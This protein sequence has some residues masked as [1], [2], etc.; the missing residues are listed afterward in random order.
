MQEIWVRSLGGDNSLEYEMATHS[1]I[2][3]WKTSRTEE[4]AGYRPRDRKES[5]SAEQQSTHA[6][7][8]YLSTLTCISDTLRKL[9]YST[10]KPEVKTI[11]LVE[12]KI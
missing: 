8:Y 5:D 6:F 7:S 10:L 3:M 12:T 1:S 11:S 2:L 4:P 9:T